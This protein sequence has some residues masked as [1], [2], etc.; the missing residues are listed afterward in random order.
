MYCTHTHIQNTPSSAF[1]NSSKFSACCSQRRKFHPVTKTSTSSASD[2]SRK[3]NYKSGIWCQR[4]S[5]NWWLSMVER[6]TITLNRGLKPLK[7]NILVKR[8]TNLKYLRPKHNM[9]EPG[10]MKACHMECVVLQ[11]LYVYRIYGYLCKYTNPPV[12]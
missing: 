1:T 11:V 3:D 5:P 12:Y 7:F 6:K 2:I 4:Y 9:S 8:T 10:T